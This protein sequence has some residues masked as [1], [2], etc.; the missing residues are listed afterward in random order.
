MKSQITLEKENQELNSKILQ[1]ISSYDIRS[2]YQSVLERTGIEG[3]YSTRCQWLIEHE[4]FEKWYNSEESSVLWLNGTIGT[5]KTTLMARA[6]REMQRS[7]MVDTDAKPLAIFLFQKALDSVVDVETCLRSL[8]RQLSWNYTAFKVQPVVEDYYNDFRKQRS[9]ESALTAGECVKLL[10]DL[11]SDV[12]TY[13]MID[14]IDECKDPEGLLRKLKELALLLNKDAD[15]DKPLHLMLCSRDDLP[16]TDYF[17]DCLTITT[18][19]AKSKTDQTFYIEKEMDRMKRLKPGS[20]FFSSEKGYADRLKKILIEKAGGLFRW[21]QIQIEKFTKRYRDEDEI[22][23]EFERLESHTTELELNKEYTR[24]LDS[25]K[26]GRNRDRAT[27]MLRLLSCCFVPL[28]TVASFGP[29]IAVLHLRKTIH[30][31]W[32]RTQA[33]LSLAKPT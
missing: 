26:S 12:E 23:D 24:L 21:T 10:K 28:I 7:E 17:H 15:E 31:L 4:D 3:L 11:V 30:A 33:G 16:I 1:S 22:E 19:P 32:C 20:L 5:G 27:K 8:V 9:D 18:S 14:A 29:L 2:T 13:I 25:L 6:I